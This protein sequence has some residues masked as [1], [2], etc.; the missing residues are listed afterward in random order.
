MEVNVFICSLLFYCLAVMIDHSPFLEL[1][2]HLF[3]VQA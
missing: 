3:K 2:V 1:L